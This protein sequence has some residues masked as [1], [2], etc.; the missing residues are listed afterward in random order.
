MAKVPTGVA[1]P[2]TAQWKRVA[3]NGRME[4]RMLDIRALR[5]DFKLSEGSGIPTGLFY[6]VDCL[7]IGS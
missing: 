6:D 5:I 7:Y 3:I 4:P 1:N 2:R